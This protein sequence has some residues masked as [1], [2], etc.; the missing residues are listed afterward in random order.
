MLSKR[1]AYPFKYFDT[2]RYDQENRGYIDHKHF[3]KMMGKSFAPSDN[4]GISR[5]I[6]E[7]SVDTIEEHHKNQLE[8]Q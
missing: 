2:C 8:K 3:L 5:R 7:E 1:S 4:D 6:V